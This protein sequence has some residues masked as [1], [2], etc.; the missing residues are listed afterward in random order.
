MRVQFL[1]GPAG[2]GK[3]LR[4][5]REIRERLKADPGGRPL[6]L[7]APRQATYQLELALLSSPDLAGYTRLQIASFER[8]ANWVLEVLQ[9]RPRAMLSEE[10]RIMVLRALLHQHRGNLKTFGDSACTPGFARRLSAQL[11]ELQQQRIRPEMLRAMVE[12][13]AFGHT[14]TPSSHV[15]A[16][17]PAALAGKL[18][19]LALL[20]DLYEAWLREQD[21]CDA[22]GLLDQA[23]EALHAAAKE[24]TRADLLI[25]A[26]WL[27]GLAELTSQELALLAALVPHC[28]EA[29]L[30]FCLEGEPR[31]DL[32]WLSTWSVI[33]QTFRRA[34]ARFAANPNCAVQVEVIRRNRDHSRFAR[35]GNGLLPMPPTALQHLEACWTTPVVFESSVGETLTLTTC[36]DPEQ[37]AV[38]AARTIVRFVRAGNRYRDCAVL[39]R[40]LDTHHAALRRE[41]TRHGIPFFLDRRE[42]VTHHPLAE[43]TRSALHTVLF[44]WRLTDW[45][46]ALKTGLTPLTAGEVDQLENVALAHGWEGSRWHRPLELPEN[47]ALASW[48]EQL[49]LRVIQPFERLRD[50][51]GDATTGQALARALR[52]LWRDF[53]VE[54]RLE[55]WFTVDSDDVTHRTVFEELDDWL[56]NLER[57]FAKVSLPLREWLP[58]LE[59]GLGA[60]TIGVIP[61]AIDQV[62][63]GAVDRSRNPDLKLVLVLGL[64]E[65]VFPLPPEAPALL[66]ESDRS[67]LEQARLQLRDDPRRWLGHERYLGYIACTRARERLVLCWSE[68]DATGRVL[69]VSPIVDHVR[70]V[71]PTLPVNRF[72]RLAT[73]ADPLHLDD[74]LGAHLRVALAVPTETSPVESALASIESAEVRA[75]VGY[76]VACENAGR[77]ARLSPAIVRQLYGSRLR[78]S[79]SR[80]EQFAACPFQFF[81]SAVLRT[82]ERDR[83]EVDAR[84]TGTFLHEVL[85]EF[86]EELTSERLRWRDVTP[87]AAGERVARIA[88]AQL[89]RVAAGVLASQPRHRFRA[90]GLVELLRE[91]VEA[92]IRWMQT[93]RFDPIAVELGIGGDDGLLPEWEIDLGDGRSL[94]FRGNIDRVDAAVIPG[95]DDALCLTVMDYKSGNK[96]FEPA[97]MQA[98]LQLQLPAYLAALCEV[99]TGSPLLG[100]RRAVPGGMFYV[101]L[102]ETARMSRRETSSDP[103]VLKHFEHTGRFSFERL[104]LFD[105]GFATASSGQFNFRL[106][107]DG[108]PHGRSSQLIRQ[109]EL[110]RLLTDAREI[111]R[112]MGRDIL[113]GNIAVDPYR[114]GAEIPCAWCEFKPVCRIDPWTHSF[115]PLRPVLGSTATAVAP[116]PVDETD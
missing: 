92:V 44:H 21:V 71:F 77:Q 102:R 52:G 68:R 75:W 19:D 93:Y 40:C 72:D 11:R 61:P 29:T 23:T 51:I 7:L 105:S 48:C 6:I 96:E 83:F 59:A 16:S 103:E 62:L 53:E 34:H 13:P 76:F 43:F 47:P 85:R 38:L 31:E 104:P 1:L 115:R 113:S 87:V 107:Q 26:L 89:D 24:G 12:P 79:A 25:E 10:G 50:D 3:T 46:A 78:T 63:I 57:A 67:T 20:L 97:R 15:P 37:E 58:V 112:V 49:R 101:R 109:H 2:S 30:A 55:R 90:A 8:F 45:F 27:D 60:L 94:A 17:V 95:R 108:E 88:A 22:G 86:H 81:V 65:G 54:A 14:M 98:G 35:A 64:N 36:P 114:K 4:C 32:P 28:R 80:L 111:L 33:S 100:G 5:L 42:S 73:A 74:L 106:K 41:F 18:H 56:D 116:G 91:F 84:K 9:V 39:V 70:Q 69:N 110:E 82:R 99:A 66:T